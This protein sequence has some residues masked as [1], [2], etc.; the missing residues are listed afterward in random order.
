MNCC[1]TSISDFTPKRPKPCPC[2]KTLE[3]RDLAKSISKISER[4]PKQT[5]QL[6]QDDKELSERFTSQDLSGLVA[7]I[8]MRKGVE[9]DGRV[10]N[11]K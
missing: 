6:W 3:I 5:G 11:L 9:S 7:R 1:Q 10:L 8:L 4:Y 2:S